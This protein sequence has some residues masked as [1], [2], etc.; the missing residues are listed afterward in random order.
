MS[1]QAYFIKLMN[2]AAEGKARKDCGRRTEMTRLAIAQMVQSED[3][4]MWSAAKAIHLIAEKAAQV[5]AIAGYLSA[6]SLGVI[7][8]TTS[9]ECAVSGLPAGTWT[10]FLVAAFV[11]LAIG[12][13]AS[14]A[15][16]ALE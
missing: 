9:V 13:L 14:A 11:S 6:V 15:Y 3:K 7:T 12:V 1:D 5:A 4:R 2:L 16:D 10:G 8:L